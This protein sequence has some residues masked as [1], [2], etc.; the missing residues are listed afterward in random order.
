MQCLYVYK[1]YII[2]AELSLCF[3]LNVNDICKSNSLFN[4]R[5]SKM[6]FKDIFAR[7]KIICLFTVFL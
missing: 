2:K 3:Y 4:L 1:I 6:Q 5:V 7:N